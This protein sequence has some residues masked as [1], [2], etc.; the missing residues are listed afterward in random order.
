MAAYN[1]YAQFMDP[2]VYGAQ[3]N[4]GIYTGGGGGM[5]GNQNVFGAQTNAGIY[6]GGGGGMAGSNTG[7]FGDSNGY[8]QTNDARTQVQDEWGRSPSDPDYGV[9]PDGG[10][11]KQGELPQSQGLPPGYGN[12]GGAGGYGMGY[13]GYAQPPAQGG[14]G[15]GQMSGNPSM[16][17]LT[18]YFRNAGPADGDPAYW[19]GVAME[20]IGKGANPQDTLG[21]LTGRAD[22]STLGGDGRPSGAFGGGGNYSPLSPFQGQQASFSRY[23]APSMSGPAGF[24]YK[25]PAPKAPTPFSFPGVHQP[26]PQGPQNNAAPP[27]KPTP[28]PSGPPPAPESAGADPFGGGG[29]YI[30]EGPNAGAWLP[31]DNPMAQDYLAKA[32][33]PDPAAEQ[34]YQAALAQW[35]QQQGAP[36]RPDGKGMGPNAGERVGGPMPTGGMS[37]DP[38]AERYQG[39]GMG[40]PAPQDPR[41]RGYQQQGGTRAETMG[42]DPAAQEAARLRAEGGGEQQFTMGG[43]GAINPRYAGDDPG[44]SMPGRGDMGGGWQRTSDRYAGQ[45]GQALP[46]SGIDPYRAGESFKTSAPFG[47]DKLANPET[48]NAASPFSASA[49]P[50]A[51]RY[52]A[53]QPFQGQSTPGFDPYQSG[54]PFQ[55]SQTPQFTPYEGAQ[56][57]Q[58]SQTPQIDRYQGPER[59]NAQGVPEVGTFNRSGE[60]NAGPKFEYDP[61]AQQQGYTPGQFAAPTEADM[62]QDPG[63]QVRFKRGQEALEQSA[64]SRGT[65]FSTGTAKALQDYGQESAS[66]EYGNVYGRRFGE[67]QQGEASKAGSAAFNANLGLTSQA[68]R[69]GQAANAFGMNQ[70][71][72][73]AAQQQSFGNEL[74]RFQTNAQTQL[75][76]QA[77]GF[78]QA[79]DTVALNEANRLNAH[80]TDAQT[81]LGQQA[82]QYGQ[83][84]NTAQMNEGNR[85]NA[86]QFNTNAGLAT[87]AQNY[88]QAA[89]TAQMNEDNQFRGSAFNA[90][91]GLAAQGQAYG[92]AA[93]TAQMNESNRMNAFQTNAQTGLAQ[94]AQQYQQSR[95]TAGFNEGN[96]F[97]AFGANQQ[98]QLAYQGQQFNQGAQAYGMNE[99]NR[100]RAN[101]AQQ[102]NSRANY[103]LNTGTQLAGQNQAFGQSMGAWQANNAADANYQQTV[104]GQ[105]YQPWAQGASNTLQTNANNQQAQMQANS[106]NSSAEQNEYNANNQN[107]WNAYQSQV[108]Q[109][110]YAAGMGLNWAQYGLGAQNQQFN[111]NAT[112][113]GMNQGTL[114]GN[115]DR[116]FNEQFSMA[117]LGANSASGLGNAGANYG[118][119]VGNIYQGQGNANAAGQVGAGNAYAQMYGNISDNM[120][121]GLGYYQNR[122]RPL[123]AQG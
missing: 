113:Y 109:G 47:Y 23:S 62:A 43:G 25:G 37:T 91:T 36:T 50:D 120:M 48:Y 112:S 102:D 34:Q 77:Q 10:G 88:G 29:V 94:N 87:Q 98:N 35:E 99:D 122:N 44:V 66:Q 75:G 38:Q 39:G 19:A 27:P 33:Q 9:N 76:Q 85:F 26:Q 2:R 123:P 105:Q 107:A 82:Q 93:N 84:A 16:A 49:V 116:D 8:P 111:Q 46:G 101:Q 106:L 32:S 104:W 55:G 72:D 22:F 97:N 68:Q 4:A 71:A 60:I 92:Q 31:K 41:V 11:F 6:T 52:D 73:M 5:G 51:G 65:L 86:A 40:M 83:A 114:W 108:Q 18:E 12:R 13:P 54:Q 59:L 103:A 45:P 61:L 119:N 42:T 89:N 21:Y 3:T 14:G 74:G 96:R 69:Y 117:Q 115:R 78:G 121:S 118:Q 20:K 58:G 1:P 53:A 30:A 100:F 7:V 81:A 110:Q 63:Y 56:P 95:D 70:S 64:A 90:T 28:P 67:F 24:N 80:Q 15:G 17:E 57:F 79:R